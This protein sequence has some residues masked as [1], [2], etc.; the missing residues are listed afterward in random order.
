MSMNNLHSVS[1][2]IVASR[3]DMG[4]QKEDMSLARLLAVG[5]CYH[6]R[7]RTVSG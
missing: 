5:N 1:G 4:Q 6:R 3:V 7:S 2:C